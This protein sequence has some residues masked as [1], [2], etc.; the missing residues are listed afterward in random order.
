MWIINT[1]DPRRVL[2]LGIVICLLTLPT[3]GDAEIEQIDSSQPLNW[4]R[5]WINPYSHRLSFI[6]NWGEV[7]YGGFKVESDYLIDFYIFD[8]ENYELWDDGE[9]ATSL[10]SVQNVNSLSWSIEAPANETYTMV[11]V[12]NNPDR[13]LMEDW[14]HSTT[15]VRLTVVP[16][17]FA[18]EMI[19]AIGLVGL[20]LFRWR[21]RRKHRRDS[22][23]SI[24]LQGSSEER[25]SL[26]GLSKITAISLII[27]GLLVI[28]IASLVGM[29][30]YQSSDLTSGIG[31]AAA[32]FLV[33]MTVLPFAS[34]REIWRR[35]NP[36][37]LALY[38]WVF[39]SLFMGN[40]Y[41]NSWLTSSDDT[42]LH[43][44]VI[45]LPAAWIS[46]VFLIERFMMNRLLRIQHTKENLG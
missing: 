34:A 25:A 32:L 21:G 29:E 33:G 40:G 4:G 19:L 46:T 7:I 16:A 13:I 2:V 44:S 38:I 26:I 9:N 35:A 14:D 12:N 45:F 41:L 1:G 11:F 17:V 39:Y 3:Y 30:E 24:E 28:V 6:R 42:L 15:Q 8:R 10:Y 37:L 5:G 27:Q 23:Q 31:V 36:D 20:I 43:F 22:T 18:L